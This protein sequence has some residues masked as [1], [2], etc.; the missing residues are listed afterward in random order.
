MTPDTPPSDQ[1]ASPAPP[2]IS[3]EDARGGEI[4]LRTRR[5]R[6]IFIAGLVLWVLL[7]ALVYLLA[8]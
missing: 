1:P 8:L 5:R 7:A 6:A 2:H 4:V 3:A